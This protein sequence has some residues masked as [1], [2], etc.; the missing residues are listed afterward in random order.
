MKCVFAIVFIVIICSVSVWAQSVPTGYQDYL[1]LG[2]EEHVWRFFGL[3]NTGEGG[4]GFPQAA[5][6]SVVG[7][8]ASAD[9][10]VV[11][12][13]QWEDGFE[14]NPLSPVQATT[15]VLG[16][17][18]SANGDANTYTN[19]PRVTSD[20][21]LSGTNLVLNSDQ[22]AGPTLQQ[23]I[24][25]S[26]GRNSADI[27]FD[28]GDR[29][30]SSG[31]PLTVIHY[32]HPATVEVIGGSTEML[33]L[34]A[35][36]E[37]S[38]Y[39]VPVGTDTFTRYG[40]SGTPGEPFKYVWLDIAAYQDGTQVTIDNKGGSVVTV[41]LNR[42]QHYS[43]EGR[44]D[45]AAS[46][47]ITI[48][49]GT[50]ISSNKPIAAILVGGGVSHSSGA[51][52]SNTFTLIPDRLFGTDFVLAAPGDNPAAGS[53][54]NHPANVYIY[55]PNPNAA[56]SVTVTDSVGT[57]TFSV[58]ANQSKAYTE[59]TAMNRALPNNSTAR[60][61]SASPFW[62]LVVHDY[63]TN[64]SDW[65]YSFLAKRFLVKEYTS[66]WSPGTSDPAGSYAIRGNR[67]PVCN[68][69]NLTC[70]SLNRAPLFIAAT[71]DNTRVQIDLNGDGIADAVD[72]D[73]NDVTNAAP[74][75]GNTYLVN[76]GEVLRVFDQ[77]DYDNQGTRITA[78]KEVIVAYGQDTDQG[79]GNDETLD[80]GNL[81]YP[82][83]SSWLSEVLTIDKTGN[84]TSLPTAGGNVVF[85]LTVKSYTSAPLSSLTISDTLPAGM[86]YVNNS[87]VITYPGGIQS[88]DNP[89]ITGQRLDFVLTST[90]M[91]ANETVTVQFTANLP[92]AQPNGLY[93][94]R[95]SSSATLGFGS[96]FK[97]STY[98]DVVKTD[99]TM[100]KSVSTPTAAPGQNL[101]YTINVANNGGSAQTNVIVT[102]PLPFGATFTGSI[103]SA[104]GF[105]TGSFDA[106][107]NAVVWTAASFGAGATDTLSFV[108][109]VLPTAPA[110]TVI[111]N[112]SL[113]ESTQTPAF[114]SLGAMTT[115]LG[116]NLVFS[117]SGPSV[118]A[119]GDRLIFT[120]AVNN[121][122]GAA[123]TNLLVVDPFPLNTAYVASSM[124]Y[125]LGAGVWLPLTDSTAGDDQGYA[126]A[127]RV[128]FH[129]ASLA[130]G[131]QVTFR[132]RVDVSGS[133]TPPASVTNQANVSAT[134]IEPR[135]TN[136]VFV[137]ILSNA[138]ITPPP[139]VSAPIIAGDTGVSGTS[140]SPNGTV[141][142]V[143]VDGVFIG[144][145][146]VSGGTWTL[147]SIGPLVAGQTVTATAQEAAKSV[148]NLSAPVVVSP[149]G[150][151]T[152][153]PVVNPAWSGD[154][155]ITGTSSS[156]DGT[157]ID[158][159][160]NGVYV[161]QTTVSSGIWILQ[162]VVPLV[163]GQVLTARATEPGKGTSTLSAPVTVQARPAILKRSSALGGPVTP[164]SRL[165]Y[166]IQIANGTGSAWNNIVVSDTVPAGTTY[167]VAST[168][169]TA[170]V[171]QTGT[172][173]DE[174]GAQLYNNTDGTLSWTTSWAESNDD[175]NAT[176]GDLAIV[177]DAVKAGNYELRLRDDNRTLTRNADLSGY[178][179]ATVSFVY[180]RQMTNGGTWTFQAFNQASST[181]ITLASFTGPGTD[182]AYQSFSANVSSYINASPST[183]A[184]FR[185]NSVSGQGMGDTEFVWIDDFQVL[186]SRRVSAT[187]AGCAPPTLV[188]AIGCNGQ[189]LQPGETMTVTF[190]VDVADC[191]TG[192][193]ANTASLTANAASQGSSTVTDTLASRDFD[194]DGILDTL[195]GCADSDGDGIANYKDLDSD[196][197]GILDSVEMRIDTDGDGVYDYLDL[198]TDNDGINDIVES[199]LNFTELAALDATGDGRIDIGNAFGTNGLAN[200]IEAGVVDSG[201]PDYDNNNT[202]PDAVANTDGTGPADFRDLDSDNDG[203]NDVI[204]GAETDADGNGLIDG[205]PNGVTGQVPGADNAVPNTDGTGLPDYR[206]LDSDGDTIN[207]IVESGQ[208][209]LDGN[210][211]GV[212]DSTTDT[213]NDGISDVAD[214]ADAVFGDAIDSDNDGI[215]NSTDIDDDNDGI[216][217]TVEGS[218]AVDTDGDGVTDSLDLDS[219]NDG[220]NDLLESGLNTIELNVMDANGDGRIDFTVAVGTNG[221]ANIIEAGA[222]DSGN[223]DYDNN[224]TGPDAVANTDGTGP[225]DFRD[226]D[227]D[228]DGINDVIE[229]AETDAD[230]NGLID[231]TPDPVTGQ[232]PGADNIA[233]NTDG[234]GLP[235]YRDLDSD[236]DGINDIVE[237]GQGYLDGNNDGVI[238]S[239]TDTDGDG[240]P[241]VA[242]GLPAAFGDARDSDNDGISDA[243][244]IDDDNDGILDTVEGPPG[245]DTDGDGVPDSLDLDSDNDGINDLVESGLNFAE[246]AVL[247]TN[248]D[249]RID[250]TIAVGTNGLADLIE[251]GAADSGNPD[252]DNNG[253]GPD[254]V[255]NTDGSGPADF[256]DLDSDNDG[257]NDVTEGNEADADGNG[258]IDGTPDP[259]TGQILGADNAVPN[260]DGTGLPDYRDLD[261]DNDGINDI[262]ESGQGYLDGNSD[263]MIDSTTDT[264]NDGIPNVADGAPAVFG[265]ARD[266]DND[267]IP[268]ATDIDDDNDGILD[269]VEGPP[270]TDTDGDGVPDAF[271]LDSDNDGLN[272]LL[273]S[274]L[275]LAELAALDLNGDGQIDYTMA[276]G[277]NGYANLIETSPDSGNPDY[278][279]NAAGPDAV[280]NTDGSGP[281]DF[282]DL[283][284]DN[285]GINDVLEGGTF[286]ANGDGLIDGTPDPITGKIPGADNAA[287]DADSDGTADYRDLDSDN[288]G[289]KDNKESGKSALDLDSDGRIDDATDADGDGLPDVSDG[290]TG[291][292]K[293]A[294]TKPNLLRN[295]DVTSIAT[296]NPSAIFTKTY[297]LAPGDTSLQGYGA[298]GRPDEWEGG[299]TQNPGSGDDDDHYISK[300]FTT[301]IDAADNTVLTDS[302]RPLVFYELSCSSCVIKLSKTAGGI[303]ITW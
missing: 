31:G 173:R 288:D 182:A 72:T 245:T 4:P 217:D 132:F 133:L 148:S 40:G 74:L 211:D 116:P 280:A 299:Q 201:N 278:D 149:I 108:A 8:S 94:N 68:G 85:T 244:D 255:A 236:N 253:S 279:N 266:S 206:D 2:N 200:A 197:D 119:P 235:D 142:R 229:G 242:D 203:I 177:N 56:I 25:M 81:L 125:R 69:V 302:G 93:R 48:L 234:T 240:I 218:G 123:A 172:Y 75:A 249:G 114:E 113:F 265:D 207:D 83:N 264:D 204:E 89:G 117:K 118:A 147:S 180:R 161:G 259:V 16:D 84:P 222:V 64:Y 176:S 262:L 105:F 231:S 251:A 29:I 30:Y 17:G 102:D 144:Q 270:G 256:R 193:I 95:A 100:T 184:R 35:V 157:L 167:V 220:I 80:L 23:V 46:T 60:L 128:E 239:T 164:G 190:Q 61:T 126:Y 163:A 109:T 34:Q 290:S 221:L 112:K 181:W 115:V 238:D 131:A 272:D 10:Q 20:V 160:V 122:G 51:Y 194:G 42:G 241:N 79:T 289:I 86:S 296:Y 219:D 275:N 150:Q 59:A 73:S 143:Y 195:D 179:T 98:F 188:G 106:S 152:P 168:Q 166:T 226:L 65:G 52:T 246:L 282:R 224:N 187:A 271:D 67:S 90:S 191:I 285:D 273:E 159:F 153:A 44:I 63:T 136:A 137:S 24:P 43:S 26:P 215:P 269:T 145:T 295:D 257:I 9:G 58:P 36:A 174:F 107:Q 178:T 192:S 28:G 291:V 209:Y 57:S 127:N 37:A 101:T 151:V 111:N 260:T 78:N 141:I 274:G 96:S 88:F 92:G 243:I 76:A 121:T 91:G 129:L 14:A 294:P 199:G 297:P 41:T 66:T 170:P 208:G 155:Q 216:L 212:I 284:S 258:L 19:D 7:A 196:N 12:Y 120:I 268:D 99:V 252:Y 77:T 286:D 298:N 247:D 55:N 300:I 27:R 82:G 54:P 158:V 162:P 104:N 292:W 186:L 227:S 110:G 45:S 156:P 301:T 130:A 225:A 138:Q 223:P 232:V 1:V 13:D 21:I 293:D 146:T 261:S 53:G 18:N 103:A 233:P 228:N 303:G 189:T 250:F 71:Q 283:D 3:I 39:S 237:S 32:Q 277:T 49:E 263:G 281:A 38:S 135:D 33:S 287:P 5:M 11:Y 154:T 87:T 124:E 15:L 276:V 213:D 198:D 22:A 139:I 140:T 50:K 97:P 202:G 267:G 175:N 134:Q 47:A 171:T 254:A 70:D 6:A 205:V 230:G 165:T 248:G 210:N 169:I 183:P 185:F 62:G 214:G